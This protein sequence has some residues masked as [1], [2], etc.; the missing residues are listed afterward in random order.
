VSRAFSMNSVRKTSRPR[1]LEE[2]ELYE[3]IPPAALAQF[4]ALSLGG[5]AL[6]FSIPGVASTF[7]APGSGYRPHKVQTHAVS[8]P[9]RA[10]YACKVVH[11]CEPPDGV[12][13]RA[14]PFF[15][16]WE[17]M[18]LD[19]LREEG[20]PSLHENLPLYVSDSF[21]YLCGQERF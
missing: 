6:D 11:S 1:R 19:V 12:S 20:H 21:S 3:S 5:S 2:D 17:G 8:V 10:L 9:N 4:K 13:Y 18:R 14:L 16:L 15:H 7:A